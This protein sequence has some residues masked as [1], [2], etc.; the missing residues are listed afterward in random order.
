MDAIA[1]KITIEVDIP[2]IGPTL[3]E[4]RKALNLSQTKVAAEADM[5]QTNLNRIEKEE[6]KSIPFATL[7]KTA[8]AVGMEKRLQQEVFDAVVELFDRDESL[9]C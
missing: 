3:A 2:D 9:P 6:A 7:I 1:V 5:S 8:K 4:A